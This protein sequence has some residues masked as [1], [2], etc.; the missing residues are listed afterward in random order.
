[1]INLRENIIHFYI[2]AESFKNSTFLKNELRV[3][4]VDKEKREI[5]NCYYISSTVTNHAIIPTK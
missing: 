3:L 2:N 4:T 5:T 1:M